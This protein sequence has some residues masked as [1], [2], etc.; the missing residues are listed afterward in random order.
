VSKTFTVEVFDNDRVEWCKAN[1]DM[2]S[3]RQRHY[4]QEFPETFGAIPSEVFVRKSAG[5]V[6]SLQLLH[7]GKLTRVVETTAGRPPT[8]AGE[9]AESQIQLRVQRSR[10]AAYVRAANKSNRTLAAWCFEHL[11]KASEY[12]G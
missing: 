10:K 6:K 9:P 8:V 5:E 1:P 3:R 11:D 7:R 12:S 4:A 2:L